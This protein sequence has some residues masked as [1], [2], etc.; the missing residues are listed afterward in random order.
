MS[1]EPLAV[2]A[3]TLVRH[4]RDD[5]RWSDGTPEPRVEDLSPDEWNLRC[6]T[7]GGGETYVEVPRGLAQETA[8]LRWVLAGARDG[9]YGSGR[10]GDHTGPLTVDHGGL[11]RMHVRPGSD[12][13]LGHPADADDELPGPIPTVVLVSITEWDAWV[14]EHPAGAVWDRIHEP[15]ILA[16]AA[17]LG[18]VDTRREAQP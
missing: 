13:L 12:P 2:L 3:G 5:W 7:Y 4:G 14:R 1:A 8:S 6:R 16:R 9:R 15:D 17:A 11:R 18:W 10:S